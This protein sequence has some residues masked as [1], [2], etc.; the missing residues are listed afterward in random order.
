MFFCLNIF[1]QKSLHEDYGTWVMEQAGNTISV[2]AF[3][4]VEE[5]K[6]CD[7]YT[8]LNQLNEVC[9]KYKLYLKSKS[10]YAGVLTSTW[11][12]GGRIVVNNVE[13]T[14]KHF[15]DGF[16]ISVGVEPTLVYTYELDKKDNSLNLGITW[17]RA[18]YE[19]RVHK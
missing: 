4:T 9:Y 10:L 17:E 13:V 18:I 11:I 1:G 6:D 3:V 14:N 12:Y 16:I 5:D 2:E 8:Q 19:P 7:K 15:P